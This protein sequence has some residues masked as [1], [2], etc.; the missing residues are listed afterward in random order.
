M[1]ISTKPE[2]P[3]WSSNSRIVRISCVGHNEFATSADPGIDQDVLT[4]KSRERG[5]RNVALYRGNLI[6]EYENHINIGRLVP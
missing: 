5:Y 2:F 4:A 6:R 1:E 3:I